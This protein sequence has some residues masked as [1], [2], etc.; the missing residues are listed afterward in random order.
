MDDKDRTIRIQQNMLELYEK[1]KSK[2]V[3]SNSSFDAKTT[4]TAN[5]ATQTDRVRMKVRKEI[6]ESENLRVFFF[7]CKTFNRCDRS[8]WAR[9]I[10]RG[11]YNEN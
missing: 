4:E 6:F 3:D 9:T 1:E 7:S 11:N 8:Q 5:T 2:N 10:S